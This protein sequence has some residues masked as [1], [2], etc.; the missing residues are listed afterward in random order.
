MVDNLYNC[1]GLF[2][3]GE[4]NYNSILH[5]NREAWSVPLLVSSSIRLIFTW[6]K[7]SVWLAFA[8]GPV[9]V[10]VA[11]INSTIIHSWLGGRPRHADVENG[12]AQS[13]SFTG[14]PV[15]RQTVASWDPVASAKR[16]S[17]NFHKQNSIPC[18]PTYRWWAPVWHLNFKRNNRFPTSAVTLRPQRLAVSWSCPAD[19]AALCQCR[20]CSAWELKALPQA[21]VRKVMNGWLPPGCFSTAISD[22]N[23]WTPR[24]ASFPHP[25]RRWAICGKLPL[26]HWDT[27]IERWPGVLPHFPYT[28]TF[29]CKLLGHDAVT[30]PATLWRLDLRV[31]VASIQFQVAEYSCRSTPQQV[32]DHHGSGSINI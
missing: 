27:E 16:W 29:A 12:D 15:A 28:L 7:F 11:P 21:G 6:D 25:L 14:S 9:V 8:V 23:S 1:Y 4:M 24:R 2:S 5:E 30:T 13:C 17:S 32:L 22:L 3:I 20:R 26:A 10:V 31:L 19:T 18:Y